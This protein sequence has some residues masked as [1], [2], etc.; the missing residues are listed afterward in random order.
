MGEEKKEKVV[1]E[2]KEKSL[3]IGSILKSIYMFVTV[4]AAFLT[5]SAATYAWFSSN[6]IVSTNKVQGR[7]GTDTVELQI[8]STGGDGFKAGSEAALAQVNASSSEMLMP[9][10]TADLRTFVINTGTVEGKAINFVKVAGEKYV[11]HGRVYLKATAQGHEGAK[12]ALYL[13]GAESAGGNFAQNVKGYVA[14]AA[15]LGLLFDGGSAKILR[16][17]ETSNPTAQQV[18]NAV[19]NGT[20]VKPGQVI[21]GS[22]NPMQIAADPSLP[23]ARFMVGDDGLAGNASVEPLLMMELNRIYA[24]DVY[25]YLEGCDPDC[26]DVTKLDSLNL[27]LA[28]YG[29]L[30]EGAN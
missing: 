10:S 22:A 27:H 25:F 17:S 19:L 5:F 1:S 16:L 23:M 29:V 13:D 21:N 6:S 20:E 4:L 9:V 8:S 28:F 12:L 3:S 26:S 18:S 11:Y 2:E 7:S 15:R 24:V 14:N 30:T